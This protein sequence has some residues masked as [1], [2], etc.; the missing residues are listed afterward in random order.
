VFKKPDI[1]SVLSQMDPV[2]LPNSISIRYILIS[3]ADLRF[4]EKSC[5]ESCALRSLISVVPCGMSSGQSFWLQ[6]QRSRSRK[7]RLTTV[8]IRCADHATPSIRKKLAL[9]LPTSGGR[10]VGIVC[11]RTKATEFSFSCVLQS[12]SNNKCAKLREHLT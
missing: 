9:I 6:I 12:T 1:V 4:L 10:S 5:S 7:Q 11:L 3:S 2:H 8:R